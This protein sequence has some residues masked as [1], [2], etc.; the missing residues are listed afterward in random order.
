MTLR[1]YYFFFYYY[2]ISFL[3][4]TNIISFSLSDIGT[5]EYKTPTAFSKAVTNSTSGGW[6]QVKLKS[7]GGTTSLFDVKR[8]LA[9]Y[10]RKRERGFQRKNRSRG[11]I[12]FRNLTYH[13]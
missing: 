11:I 5:I 4:N 8:K 9:G 2:Q 13:F 6:Q 10:D 12:Y 3:H 1:S 7:S